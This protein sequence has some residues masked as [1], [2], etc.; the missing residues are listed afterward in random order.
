MATGHLSINFVV[1]RFNPR[2]LF[3]NKWEA[4]PPNMVAV[5]KHFAFLLIVV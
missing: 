1:W 5:G 4:P 3:E 2:V